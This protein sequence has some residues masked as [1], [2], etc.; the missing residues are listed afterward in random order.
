MFPEDLPCHIRHDGVAVIGQGDLVLEYRPGGIHG[1]KVV[2]AEGAPACLHLD[3][4]IAG[5]IQRRRQNAE[6]HHGGSQS[7]ASPVLQGLPGGIYK[8]NQQE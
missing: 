6:H 7:K 5:E 3:V 2:A 1:E 8:G 4:G